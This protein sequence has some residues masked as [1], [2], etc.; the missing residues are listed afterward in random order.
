MKTSQNEKKIL[1]VDDI[2]EY[3]DIIEMLM[4]EDYRIEKA[5]GLDQAKEIVEKE[6]FALAIVDVRLKEADA[7]NKEGLEFLRWI[8]GKNPGIPVIMISAYKEFEFRAES[9]S[10]GA[11]YFL[12]KPINPQ[13]L[14]DAI[15]NILG[16]DR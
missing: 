6:D 7:T 8:K 11:Q 9:L 10:L 15:N 1:I 16:K 4:P 12:E 2:P 14:L 13:N 5:S 3:V